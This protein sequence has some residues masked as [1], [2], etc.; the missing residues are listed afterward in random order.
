MHSNSACQS[1]FF[2]FF[3]SSFSGHS[4][5]E[6][7]FWHSCL[8][9]YY[10]KCQLDMVDSIGLRFSQ[11]SPLALFLLP[12]LS[13]S[14]SLSLSLCTIYR[15]PCHGPPPAFLSSLPRCCHSQEVRHVVFF[16]HPLFVVILIVI[17]HSSL[18]PC[19]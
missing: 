10:T 18:V 13:L 16:S 9:F 2:S 14:L 1:P 6:C 4:S 8:L 11:I 12:I 5:L 17:V 7:P 15:A 19:H 3:F